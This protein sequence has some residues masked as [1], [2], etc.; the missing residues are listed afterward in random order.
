MSVLEMNIRFGAAAV[1]AIVVLAGAYLGGLARLG[2]D[3]AWAVQ[4]AWLGIIPGV[5]A[6]V[7][8]TALNLT[9]MA[10]LILSLGGLVL[11]LAVAKTGA[12]RLAAFLAPAS[13]IELSSRIWDSKWAICSFSDRAR[14]EIG[15]D[16]FLNHPMSRGHRSSSSR[17]IARPTSATGQVN[18]KPSLHTSA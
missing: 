15:S 2:A 13:W 11:A 12:R 5:A 18:A 4:A 9:P 10:R 6:I 14:S 8:L 3:P 7:V 1:A 17:K 16:F